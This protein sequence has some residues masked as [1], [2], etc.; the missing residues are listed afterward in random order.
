M[1]DHPTAPATEPHG[2]PHPVAVVTGASAGVGRAVAVELARQG[3]D[4]ALLARGRAGLAGA[5]ADVHQLGR[6]AL[7]LPTDV[8]DVDAVR[9]SAAAVEASLGPI[10][11]WVNDAMATTFAPV[12]E[13]EPADLRRAVEVT[14]LGQVWGTMAALDVMRPRD[15]GHIVNVGSALSYTG[16]PLQ[17]A[18][19]A[20]KFACRG[21]FES[22]RAE[23]L[24]EGSNVRLSMV[25]L[26]AVNTPQFD[27]ARSWTDRRIRPVAPVYQPEVVAR[28]VVAVAHDARRAKVVGA[29]NRLVVAAARLAPATTNHF[30]ALKRVERPDH[31]RAAP[32][33]PARQPVRPRRRGRGPRRSRPLRRRGGRHA[34]PLVPAQPAGHAPL[35]PGGGGGADPRGGSRG[36]RA[37]PLDPGDAR[38]PPVTDIADL[39]LLGD[40]RT[41]AL[42]DRTGTVVWMCWPDFADDALL[43]R[44]LDPGGGSWSIDAGEPVGRRYLP[45]SVV[46]EQRFRPSPSSE[47]VVTDLLVPPP[48]GG[49]WLVRRC[50]VAASPPPCGRASRP[51]VRF[52]QAA[53][54][55]RAAPSGVRFEGS[56]AAVHLTTDGT[57]DV[58]DGGVE[59]RAEVSEDR[60]LVMVLGERTPDTGP[61]R[62]WADNRIRRTADHWHRWV[63]SLPCPPRP[64]RWWPARRSR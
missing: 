34:R 53:A 37:G 40:Q 15:R 24:H 25:H 26:P 38:G 50:E 42:V 55:A 20:S 28:S 31:R 43:C 22:V 5:V 12:W 11:L 19:C 27:W 36:A 54:P 30:A 8:A 2:D 63:G 48:Q 16:I 52:G 33:R 41:A 45:D 44:L 1:P 29:W 35:P 62:E 13:I 46:L 58:V 64:A 6:R 57:V 18:Y 60:P 7:P 21:F 59:V 49:R 14:F 23:L 10:D 9:R 56:D 51:T 61:L 17:S 4:V 39:A 3:Y 32:G 47:V